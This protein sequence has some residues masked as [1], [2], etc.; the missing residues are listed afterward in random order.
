[1]PSRL[2]ELLESMLES[3][4]GRHL[5]PAW[6]PPA[7]VYRCGGDWLIKLDLAGVRP[8]DVQ[9]HASGRRLTIRGVRRDWSIQEGNQSYSME[10]AYNRFQRSIELPC[11]LEGARIATDYR[12]GMLLIRLQTASEKR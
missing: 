12:D 2:F 7:D 5:D 4:G 11:E 10:I 8:Q 9:V 6:R 3:G 1:M